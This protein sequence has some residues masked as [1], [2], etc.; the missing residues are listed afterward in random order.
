MTI[1]NNVVP[2]IPCLSPDHVL[3]SCAGKY[4]SVLVIGWT[5]DGEFSVHVGGSDTIGDTFYMA[6]LFCHKIMN[7]DYME[8][9][10]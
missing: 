1:N 4:E 7:G 6:S 10:K 9:D 2:I 5:K 3:E 8:A